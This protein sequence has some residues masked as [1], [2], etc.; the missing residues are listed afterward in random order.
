MNRTPV[1]SSALVS[2]G[3]DRDNL[4]L[5]TELMGGAV[6]QYFDVPESVYLEL[7]SAASLGVFYNKNIRNNYRYAQL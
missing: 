6:Y 2:V 4:L 7:M 3:Y 1:D 5:E